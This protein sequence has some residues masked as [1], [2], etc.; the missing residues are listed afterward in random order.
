[1]Q[2]IEMDRRLT[3]IGVPLSACLLLIPLTFEYAYKWC[4]ANI[5]I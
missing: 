4:P 3:I 2:E 5:T 1:M